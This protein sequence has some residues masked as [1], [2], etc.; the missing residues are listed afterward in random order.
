MKIWSKLVKMLYRDTGS[1]RRAAQICSSNADLLGRS[2]G[3]G[4]MAGPSWDFA[5]QATCGS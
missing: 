4:R 5:A 1:R 2:A 3:P